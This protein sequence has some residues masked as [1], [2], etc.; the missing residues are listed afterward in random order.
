MKLNHFMDDFG[1][2][3]TKVSQLIKQYNIPCYEE[4][5]D[6]LVDVEGFL[7]A[8][9]LQCFRYLHQHTAKQPE[10]KDDE[11]L[12]TTKETLQRL[13]IS[14]SS[15]YRLR[16]SGKIETT[17]MGRKTLYKESEVERLMKEGGL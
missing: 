3:S 11:K 8:L 16:D 12:L 9:R 10:A 7:A 2:S 1:L 14:R 15:L 6:I 5:D 4:D 13:N 17:Y